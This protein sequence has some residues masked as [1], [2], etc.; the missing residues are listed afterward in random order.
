MTDDGREVM[1]QVHLETGIGSDR[2]RGVAT[3]IGI[4]IITESD[5]VI[6][7][8]SPGTGI[9]TTV[10]I[11]DRIVTGGERSRGVLGN[12]HYRSFSYSLSLPRH[13]GNRKCVKSDTLHGYVI[14]CA[15]AT[16]THTHTHKHT[17]RKIYVEHLQLGSVSQIQGFTN[18][19]NCEPLRRE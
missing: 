18:I 13:T 17:Y 14:F 6:E 12:Y 19:F 11:G 1:I 15:H 7:N 5:H 9:M 2:K 8:D 4:G 3:E 16:S 10:G